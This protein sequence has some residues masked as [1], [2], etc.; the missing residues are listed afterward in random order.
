MEKKK[1]QIVF[2]IRPPASQHSSLASLKQ[3]IPVRIEFD[4]DKI[5]GKGLYRPPSN[6]PEFPLLRHR[7]PSKILAA[8]T[9]AAPHLP[10][11]IHLVLFHS[12]R[13]NKEAAEKRRV[14]SELAAT[15]GLSCPI[16]NSWTATVDVTNERFVLEAVVYRNLNQACWLLFPQQ[17]LAKIDDE[18]QRTGAWTRFLARLAKFHEQGKYIHGTIDW[19]HL[20]TAIRTRQNALKH[21]EFYLIGFESAT[22]SSVVI[23]KAEQE[24]AVKLFE[25]ELKNSYGFRTGTRDMPDVLVQFQC[26]LTPS[27]PTPVQQAWSL[28]HKLGAGVY[29]TVFVVVN[30]QGK[31]ETKKVVKFTPIVHR[32]D[33]ELGDLNV[34]S[35]DEAKREFIIAQ[36]AA[37][38]GLGP[39]VDAQWFCNDSTM[40]WG[41]S[42]IMMDYLEGCET[43]AS[44]FDKLDLKKRRVLFLSL[45]QRLLR[46]HA[47]GWT[48]MD[49][50]Q[51]NIMVCGVESKAPTAWLIDYS[52]SGSSYDRF[53]GGHHNPGDVDIL[54]D[55]E[56]QRLCRDHDV[57]LPRLEQPLTA[58]QQRDLVHL[59]ISFQVLSSLLVKE[60]PK[61]SS[62]QTKKI[63][64]AAVATREQ[65]YLP[66]DADSTAAGPFPPS[67]SPKALIQ[68]L[69]QGKQWMWNKPPFRLLVSCSTRGPR[70]TMNMMGH[71]STWQL[72]QVQSRLNCLARLCRVPLDLVLF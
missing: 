48:H 15:V 33:T 38:L 9:V 29:G 60:E 18:K 8:E 21:H 55:Q 72:E 11:L 23:Q 16:V 47:L 68:A 59:A 67:I 25:V 54:E 49:I 46:F 39:K 70:L 50:H 30:N 27:I 5:N 28:V 40:E 32:P 22:E 14:A 36:E 51:G 64:E 12:T 2:W 3:V 17:V 43:L 26:L 45:I 19:H 52:L 57:V 62:P 6:G 56:F 65:F 20:V 58:A 1:T 37:K 61:V 53:P 4:D 41:I 71:E 7:P 69:K 34:Q 63:E 35:A 66:V 31:Q 44:A 24:R 42:C 13:W 10:V